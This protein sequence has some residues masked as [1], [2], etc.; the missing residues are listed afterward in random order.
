MLF[1]THSRTFGPYL[2]GLAGREAPG[3]AFRLYTEETFA[4]LM[5]ATPPEIQRSNLASVVLQV[6]AGAAPQWRQEQCQDIR[7]FPMG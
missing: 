6:G 4:A 3:K 5:P 1:G 7:S 2:V